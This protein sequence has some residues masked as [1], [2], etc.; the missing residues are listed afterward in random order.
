MKQI[1][2]LIASL[3]LVALTHAANAQPAEQAP[4]DDKDVSELNG[5]LVPVGE[6][7]RFR[8]SY[9]KVN[10]STNPLGIIV[11][12]YG[13]SASYAVNPRVAVRGDIN[14][15]KP[16]GGDE[17]GFELGFGAPVYFRKMYS[18]LF[19]EPGVILRRLS[20]GDM[21]ET[22]TVVGPQ[23]L[24]GWHWYWDSG[25]NLA[26]AAGVGRNWNNSDSEEFDDYDE[27]FANGYVR[28]GYAF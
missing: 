8:H 23:A 10:V 7:N 3:T 6:E 1:T 14:Y 27:L 28:F 12:S 24:V 16:I 20:A 9:K 18:G 26:I 21:D 11:G 15:Y 4:A 5:Q 22:A 25:L 17:S 2:P 19:L 13:L